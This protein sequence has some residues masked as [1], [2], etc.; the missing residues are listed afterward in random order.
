MEQIHPKNTLHEDDKLHITEIFHDDVEPRLMRMHAR[1]GNISCEFAGEQYKNWVI[2]FKSTRYGFE[3][4]DFEYDENSRSF[5]LAP[6]RH[7]I[8]IDEHV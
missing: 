2:E 7:I 3:I 4:V 6:E 8:Q 5:E 1:T